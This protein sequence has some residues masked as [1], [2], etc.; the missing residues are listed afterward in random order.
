MLVTH[1]SLS[2]VTIG[3]MD[4]PFAIIEKNPDYHLYV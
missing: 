3:S 1:V 2:A 4:T